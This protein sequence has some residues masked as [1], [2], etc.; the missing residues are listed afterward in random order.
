MY[1]QVRPFRFL[2]EIRPV[3]MVSAL[4][5][6]SV[7][8]TKMRRRAEHVH[9]QILDL[10]QRARCTNICEW[11]EKNPDE[12]REGLFQT[13]E[14]LLK[15][16]IGTFRDIDSLANEEGSARAPAETTTLR[17]ELAIDQVVDDDDGDSDDDEQAKINTALQDLS[18]I[19][20]LELQQRLHR[21]TQIHGRDA[22][23]FLEE[24]D[25]ILRRIVKALS[26]AELLLAGIL[27]KPA[28]L[29]F[30]SE[31]MIAL[32][33]RKIYTKLKFFIG[34][35]APS[36]ESM[37]QTLRGIGTHIAMLVGHDIYPSLRIQDRQQLRNVQLQLLNWL[38][39]NTNFQYTEGAHLWQNI[40]SCVCL[41]GRISCRQEL[42]EHDTAAVE[43]LL[44]QLPKN[45]DP[46]LLDRH[47]ETLSSLSGLSDEVDALL[48]T[49][50]T[51][52]QWRSCLLTLHATFG[53]RQ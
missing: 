32:R 39:G 20:I 8:P 34:S 43:S 10:T 23:L 13:I 49:T 40:Q 17:F 31:L 6:V 2:S 33:I 35:E 12:I 46:A 7:Q 16:T 14:G 28:Q 47:R 18:F 25:S 52:A 37:L 27:G 42:V 5:E 9:T 45:G 15:E 19:A 41:F 3:G 30:T 36:Q 11:E 51:V 26:A 22:W 50:P 29:D 24:C 4:K 48:N 53:R 38:R 21:L 44:I 1:W